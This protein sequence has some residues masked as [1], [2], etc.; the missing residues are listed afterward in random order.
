MS[1]ED[2]FRLVYNDHLA[3]EVPEG[4]LD[5][6]LLR[7]ITL[8][9]LEAK[10]WLVSNGGKEGLIRHAR[11]ALFVEDEVQFS[12]WR[13][14]QDK[15]DPW[16][17]RFWSFIHVYA[18]DEGVQAM[19]KKTW[20]WNDDIGAELYDCIFKFVTQEYEALL[21]APFMPA[22]AENILFVK[23][24]VMFNALV[25]FDRWSIILA[26]KLRPMKVSL[27][28]NSYRLS[29]M[30]MRSQ[31]AL[32]RDS[33]AAKAKEMRRQLKKQNEDALGSAAPVAGEDVSMEDDISGGGAD[34]A[35]EGE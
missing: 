20:T 1:A 23:W 4:V 14:F 2:E 22:N 34:G 19:V 24:L 9:P 27:S 29:S 12:R 6:F 28:R 35:S 18:T 33:E 11:D 25:V 8:N 7:R 10:E 31:A 32:K 26:G 15:P 21:D 17:F 13:A 30:D 5:R 16:L 3:A